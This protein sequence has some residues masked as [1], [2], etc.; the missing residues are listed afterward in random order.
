[1]SISTKVLRGTALPMRQALRTPLN[2]PQIGPEP[3]QIDSSGPSSGLLGRFRP[4]EGASAGLSATRG[5][6]AASGGP[7]VAQRSLRPP[8][9][10]RY[11]RD[12][13]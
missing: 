8:R 2:P 13:P 3:S 7:G 12:R 6:R 1:M 9:R 10:A 11:F 5:T 4:L